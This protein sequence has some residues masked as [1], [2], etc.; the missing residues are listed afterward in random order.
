MSNLVETGVSVFN[1]IANGLVPL[2][3]EAD[4][5]LRVY[6]CG[7]TVYADS[8]LGH[9]R[10]YVSLDMIRRIITDYFRIPTTW[11][12]N[13]TDIDDKII[14]TYRE[15]GFSS[16]TE[17]SHNRE[18][19]FFKDMD[20][21]NIR[22]PDALLRVSEVM[23]DI[24]EFIEELIK[25]GFAYKS[26]KDNSVY[27]NVMKYANDPRFK[28][29]E[30]EPESFN[31]SNTVSNEKLDGDVGKENAADFALWKSA[32]E[33][34]PHWPSPWGEGRPGWHIE[35]STMSTLF[36]GDHFDVHCGG[37]DL[38]F[39]HHTNEVAQSQAR[40]GYVPWVH[41]WLHTGQ[42]RINGEK[43]S[44][45]LGNFKSISNALEKYTWRQ[46][47]LAFALVHWQNVLELN[48]E[49]LASAESLDKRITN[50]LEMA[51][52]LLQTGQAA[53]VHGYTKANRD[54]DELMATVAADVRTKFANNFDISGA[55]ESIKTLIDAAYVV[56]GP[57]KAQ[58][59]AAARFV[60]DIMNILGFATETLKLTGG[61]DTNLGP[62]AQSMATSR[63]QFRQVNKGLIQ[64]V[65]AFRQTLGVNLKQPAPED[66]EGRKKYEL[67]KGLDENV[68]AL[69]AELDNLRDDVL[70]SVGIRLEDNSDGT[71]AFKL[72][73]PEDAA[74][75]EAKKATLQKIKD[76]QKAKQPPKQEKT[77]KPPPPPVED[78]ATM[79]TSQTDKYSQFDENGVPTHDEKG[80]PL[81]KSRRNKLIKQ[82][83]I[84]KM[85]YEKLHPVDKKE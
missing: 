4:K 72:G 32:K 46:L 7:P 44:K 19:A 25:S 38:R 68:K 45:S 3:K 40:H 82:Y 17:Y 26:T 23:P 76:E 42:L 24:I 41:T 21:L 83:N 62:L 30:L 12:M 73:D 55:I 74:E 61:N 49:L 57:N 31:A 13:V 11:A 33:G 64:K 34:E 52:G 29:A 80:E 22:R 15:A 27:F 10:T 79:F 54:F 6:T 75:R 85:K 65:S 69:F 50:F 28:Y 48:A 66:E 60:H 51:E 2:K 1:T 56:D 8:H 63:Q 78:P 77:V 58:I 67:V 5:P 39:P 47:R 14:N 36:F 43:M 20:R 16:A 71:V 70:P 59:I 81:P 35:C 84:Q 53:D 37:I 9:A 18:A